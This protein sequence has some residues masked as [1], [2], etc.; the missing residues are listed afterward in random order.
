VT[1]ELSDCWEKT[2][3]IYWRNM[4]IQYNHKRKYNDDLNPKGG[5][6]I[7]V[8]DI[9]AWY[10]TQAEPDNFFSA[11]VGKARCSDDD[12]YNKKTGRELAASRMKQTKLTIV[13]NTEYGNERFVLLRDEKGHEY[14]FRVIKGA[15]V[16][17]FVEYE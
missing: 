14:L 8:E 13:S 6:T 5:E 7:A 17:H 11:L 2:S 4:G 10:L 15:K 12:L 9:Q 1:W 3:I 16:G